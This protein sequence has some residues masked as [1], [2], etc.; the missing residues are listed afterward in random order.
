MG[1]QLA[2]ALAT[3]VLAEMEEDF[4]AHENI[5]PLIW[6][7]YIGDIPLVWPSGRKELEQ[8]LFR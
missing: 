8:F 1:T 4:L 6:K 2:R 7:R 3:L 5:Q